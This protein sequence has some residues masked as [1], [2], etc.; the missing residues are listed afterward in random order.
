MPASMSAR[1]ETCRGSTGIDEDGAG[2]LRQ[3]VSA[4]VPCLVR[5]LDSEEA[6]HR[7]LLKP[8]PRVPLVDAG[9]GGK[10]WRRH[11]TIVEGLIET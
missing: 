5:G 9:R 7:L 11:R 8:L 6:G 2:I 10:L 4:T 1:G 3:L